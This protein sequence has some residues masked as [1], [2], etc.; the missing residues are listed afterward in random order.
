MNAA[1][2]FPLFVEISA[3]TPDWEVQ[4]ERLILDREPI[5]YRESDLPELPERLEELLIR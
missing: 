3:D 1:N 4:L 5:R 2:L